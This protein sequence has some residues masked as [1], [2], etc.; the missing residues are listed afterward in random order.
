VAVRGGLYVAPTASR[1]PLRP[2]PSPPRGRVKPTRGSRGFERCRWLPSNRSPP[3][4]G[5]KRTGA[6]LRVERETHGVQ[7]CTRRAV[8]AGEDGSRRSAGG[9]LPLPPRLHQLAPRLVAPPCCCERAYSGP[10]LPPW[11]RQSHPPRPPSS[12]RP[13]RPPPPGPDPA[14]APSVSRPRTTTA[15]T[16]PPSSTPSPTT[17]TRP[18]PPR[19]TPLRTT[20]ARPS[21]SAPTTTTTTASSPTAQS[22]SRARGA[23]S[24]PGPAAAARTSAPSA[25]RST[26]GATLA[27]CVQPLSPPP[28]SLMR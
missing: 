24:A 2:L 25:S 14:P 20:T 21:S 10:A 18:H 16:V 17:T 12:R 4:P 5:S 28:S 1:N 15:T 6:L 9:E 19:A 22:S 8:V 11:P 23:T 26:R 7:S 13:P 27:R 3:R